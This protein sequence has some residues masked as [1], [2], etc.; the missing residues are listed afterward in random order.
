MVALVV[1]GRVL[2]VDS[3]GFGAAGILAVRSLTYLQQLNTATHGFLEARP[4]LGPRSSLLPRA[5]GACVARGDIALD[6]IEE[7]SSRQSAT[8][9]SKATRPSTAST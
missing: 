3:D 5:T 6:K 1:L 9:M 4:F 2:G 7:M 8:S